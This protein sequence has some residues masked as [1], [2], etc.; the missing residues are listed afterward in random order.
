MRD[1]QASPVELD[2]A[3]LEELTARLDDGFLISRI[4]NVVVGDVQPD[5]E[6]ETM[7]EQTRLILG[8]ILRQLQRGDPSREALGYLAHCL[9]R[10]LFDQVDSL[11]DAFYLTQKRNAG[12]QRISDQVERRTVAAYMAVIR[13]HIW[14]YDPEIGCEIYSVPSKVNRRDAY[15][16]AFE[17]Y[18]D[19]VG[20]D[21][22]EFNDP[23]KKINQTIKPL[24]R[25][26]GV[27]R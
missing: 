16:A 9:Q 19:A 1:V 25:R 20:K 24:L 12:G 8:T 27:L 15:Q 23:E 10:H 13:K 11:D 22:D 6:G 26:K 14:E 17:A 18:R 5:P 7:E 3:E 4:K 21:Y 2:D